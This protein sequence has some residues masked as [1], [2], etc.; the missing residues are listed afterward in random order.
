MN[1]YNFLNREIE[2]G[3]YFLGEFVERVNLP[4]DKALGLLQSNPLK[5]IPIFIHTAINTTAELNE[6]SPISLKEVIK[7]VDNLGYS[8]KEIQG[9]FEVFTKSIE[10]KLEAPTTAK[11]KNP[12]KG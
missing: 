9:M 5:Y 2:F 4:F 10:T 8:S 6:E 3:T 7:E 1:K 11:K 12:A